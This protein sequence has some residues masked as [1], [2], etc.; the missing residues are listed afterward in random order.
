M[1]LTDS[2]L[3]EDDVDFGDVTPHMPPQQGS[4]PTIP[5]ERVEKSPG[6]T[7]CV[8]EPDVP[9]H[10]TKDPPK[11]ENSSPSSDV[12]MDADGDE[13]QPDDNAESIES[14][15]EPEPVS[16]DEVVDLNDQVDQDAE[17]AVSDVVDFDDE[18]ENDEHT[19]GPTTKKRSRNP[20]NGKI[21]SVKLVQ[22]AKTKK[23][24]IQVKTNVS[25]GRDKKKCV[26]V[27]V[28]SKGDDE[29][30]K[31]DERKDDG[32]LNLFKYVVLSKHNSPSRL[33]RRKE[34]LPTLRSRM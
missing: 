25:V 22:A 6:P 18:E 30:W 2:V 17:D 28:N 5:P 12:D 3:T 26:V 27:V 11:H 24:L 7:I 20:E 8:G 33:D 1:V 4:P 34:S 23:P 10:L 13:H 19:D 9:R 21:T 32:H 14:D 31:F 15:E 29:E 16:M